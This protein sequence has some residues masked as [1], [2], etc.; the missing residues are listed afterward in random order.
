MWAVGGLDHPVETAVQR[1]SLG[2]FSFLSATLG[3]HT[4]TEAEGVEQTACH[5]SRGLPATEVCRVTF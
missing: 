2:S 4:G 3:G 1:L 5:R